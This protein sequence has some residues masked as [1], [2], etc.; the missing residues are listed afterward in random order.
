MLEGMVRITLD[1]PDDVAARLREAAALHGCT[2][3]Q[4]AARAVGFAIAARLSASLPL[5][6]R[7]GPPQIVHLHEPISAARLEEIL[8]RAKARAFHDPSFTHEQLE[9]MINEG[10]P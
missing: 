4:E 3:E 9:A 6:E 7:A 8:E 5:D 2:P 1:L 10:R